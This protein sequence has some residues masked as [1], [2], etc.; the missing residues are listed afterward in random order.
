[1][2]EFLAGARL[3]DRL[4]IIR[5][6]KSVEQR[7]D[8]KSYVPDLRPIAETLAKEIPNCPGIEGW[9]LGYRSAHG[10]RHALQLEE[11]QRFL[12]YRDVGKLFD[13]K[14][15][16][17]LTPSINGLHLLRNEQKDGT[18]LH[19]RK[20]KEESAQ[21]FMFTRGVADAICFPDSQKSAVNDLRFAYRQA[22]G[23]AFAAEFLAPANE[24]LSMWNDGRDVISIA[25]E[26][27]VYPLVIKHQIEN[28]DRIRIA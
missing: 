16:F 20:T 5:W 19:V 25:E 18:H 11:T 17:E 28:A 27:G 26:F 1:L 14:S 4:K 6:I 2:I 13:I 24:V 3:A 12:T 8:Y 21:L 22:A 15:S 9:R 7:P 10:L 23:R